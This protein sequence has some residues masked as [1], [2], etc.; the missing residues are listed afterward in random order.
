MTTEEREFWNAVHCLNLEVEPS[1]VR[2]ITASAKAA[3]SAATAEAV[4]GEREACAARLDARAAMVRSANRGPR[5]H[6]TDTAEWA[7]LILDSEAAAIR[8]RGPR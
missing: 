7:A 6:V 5:G 4:R 1:I 8:A 3:L 2:D